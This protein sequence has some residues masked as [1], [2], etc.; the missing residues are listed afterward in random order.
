MILIFLN[1]TTR[2]G[3]ALQFIHVPPHVEIQYSN[4][5]SNLTEVI[6]KT[7]QTIKTWYFLYIFCLISLF[8]N[9]YSTFQKFIIRYFSRFGIAALG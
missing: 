6:L 4:W 7:E 3:A 1:V 5:M 8:I 9:T 2:R